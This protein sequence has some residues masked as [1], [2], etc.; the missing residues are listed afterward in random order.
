[1][2]WTAIFVGCL[3]LSVSKTSHDRYRFVGVVWFECCFRVT[4]VYRILLHCV[5]GRTAESSVVVCQLE[6]KG[7][8]IRAIQYQDPKTLR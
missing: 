1:M 3:A 7:L 4:L 8:P 5:V 6:E 2:S